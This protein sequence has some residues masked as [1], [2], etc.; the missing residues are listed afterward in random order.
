MRY[1]KRV[2]VIQVFLLSLS[3]FTCAQEPIATRTIELSRE[4]PAICELQRAAI[5]YAEVEPCKIANWRRQAALKA[6][7]PDISV[8][9]DTDIYKTISSSSKDGKSYFWEG[10]DDGAKGWDVSA[11]WDLGDLIYNDDQ[12]SIDT[13]SK[14]M[15]QLRND[16]LEDL[17]A[18]YFERKKL[19]KQLDRLP[20]KTS[21]AYL[22]REIKIEEL[23]ATID[24][25]TGGYLSRRMG[26]E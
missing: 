21:D 9:Y 20:D 25:L 16:V 26:K 19:Q 6:I 24:G 18:A 1:L 7:L 4:E 2:L 23:T 11:S 5:K 15:V 13:R 22:E 14:L 8:G 3:I 10:P 17:N 12:T